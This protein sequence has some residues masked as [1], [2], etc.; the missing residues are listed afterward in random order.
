L[1]TVPIP[2]VLRSSLRYFTREPDRLLNLL[3]EYRRPYGNGYSVLLNRV[4][5]R[6]RED[7]FLNIKPPRD[8]R[9]L[10]RLKFFIRSVHRFRDLGVYEEVILK[11]DYGLSS[12]KKGELVI[13]IGAHIGFFSICA[14]RR[15]GPT[16]H[17]YSYEPMCENYEILKYNIRQN[18]MQRIIT[19]A[20]LA[21]AL[22]EGPVDLFISEDNTGGH[23]IIRNTVAPSA[24][25]E[26][27]QATTLKRVI[28]DNAIEACDF[29]KMDCEGAEWD[30]LFSSEDIL[31]RIKR[32]ALEVH[33]VG[34]R[35]P[36]DLIDFL[37]KNDFTSYFS[38]IHDDLA[39]VKSIRSHAERRE[40]GRG[41]PHHWGDNP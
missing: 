12:L 17:V 27:V 14:G 13:D 40:D 3:E 29:L 23:G 5:F 33:T 11:D 36:P 31:P 1:T 28:E 7:A 18:R 26:K 15:V 9:G 32:M 19:P 34:D 41:E 35:K 24:K 25:I 10:A 8:D 21:V 22:R 6:N 39:I 20:K 30:I 37:N 2:R 16:G 38:K 4:R